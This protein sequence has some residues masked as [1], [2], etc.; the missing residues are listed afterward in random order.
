MLHVCICRVSDGCNLTRLIVLVAGCMPV[1]FFG[2]VGVD[3][4]PSDV[5]RC[6][7]CAGV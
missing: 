3:G 7:I 5:D 4:L 1:S 6:T 2:Y